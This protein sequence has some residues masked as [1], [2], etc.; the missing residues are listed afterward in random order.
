[1]TDHFATARS[2][3]ATPP[4][5]L[6]D[7]GDDPLVAIAAWTEA[8]RLAGEPQPDAMSL[9][10]V[11]ATGLPSVRTVLLKKVDTGLV[12]FT[13]YKSA[14]AAD[15]AATAEAA[16]NLV[17]LT[18]HRQ[19][20]AAGPVER[21]AEAESD[22]Y[23]ATRPRGA[24]I[25]AAASRQSAPM[26]DRGE[27]ESAFAELAARH[28]EDVPRP[29]NWGGFRLTPRRVEFWQGRQNRMHDRFVFTRAGLD[30]SVERLW[31]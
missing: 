23:F 14:K 12:F 26:R 25:A 13:N 8:A 17:W 3:Y 31:P 27:L 19:V 5:S 29:K 10:T 6:D 9:A 22:D 1:M 28:P 21:I 15:L 16:V 20:R 11:S 18:I 4:L 30:W 7:I 24:Q 2:D